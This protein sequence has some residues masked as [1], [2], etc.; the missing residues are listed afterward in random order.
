[1]K[2][3]LLIRARRVYNKNLKEVRIIG[4]TQSYKFLLVEKFPVSY[5]KIKKGDNKRVTIDV[6]SHKNISTGPAILYNDNKLILSR[7]DKCYT[8]IDI[9]KN[10]LKHK[11][12]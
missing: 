9:A 6:F 1:M 7:A 5:V 10:L 3:K 8:I 11:I 12:K 4:I 2:A